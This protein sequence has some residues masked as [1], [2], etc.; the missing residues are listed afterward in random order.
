MASLPSQGSLLGIDYGA[1]RIG[2]ALCDC[3][4]AIAAPLS[5]Y[6][7]TEKVRDRA[8]FQKLVKQHQVVGLVV[9]LPV[10]LRSGTEGKLAKAA[11]R[12][13]DWLGGAV[14]LPVVYVDERLTTSLAHRLLAESGVKVKARQD[15]VDKL[16]AQI[17]LQTYLDALPRNVRQNE[18]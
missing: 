13:G 11:R 1:R 12:F 8:Y 4:Q 10:H 16:A 15:K 7:L 2:L 17:I 9:G 6:E 14:G 5:L 18:G 3:A